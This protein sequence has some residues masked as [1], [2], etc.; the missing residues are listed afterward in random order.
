MVAAGIQDMIFIANY[1][2]CCTDSSYLRIIRRFLKQ[3]TQTQNYIKFCISI[4][5]KLIT[6]AVITTHTGQKKKKKKESNHPFHS[7]GI[8]IWA[9]KSQKSKPCEDV[10]RLTFTNCE[11][12]V[13]T[14]RIEAF[15]N[16]GCLRGQKK[17][18]NAF[19]NLYGRIP[20]Q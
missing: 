1:F 4:K 19:L 10:L 5:R 18:A 16:T 6:I 13:S 9:R 14:C 17:K 12:C 8:L 20:V 11:P 7:T 3:Y 2:F 15:L